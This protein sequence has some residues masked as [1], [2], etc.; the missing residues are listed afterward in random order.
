MARSAV[1]TRLSCFLGFLILFGVTPSAR[2]EWS[3]VAESK[4]SYT[5]DVTNFSA[6]RRL[7]FSERER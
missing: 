7:K 1:P 4:V 6:S 3:A 5:D 2:A